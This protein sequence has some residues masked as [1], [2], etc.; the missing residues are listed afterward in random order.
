MPTIIPSTERFALRRVPSAMIDGII[1]TVP[2]ALILTRR[3]PLVDEWPLLAAL[4]AAFTVGRVCMLSLLWPPSEVSWDREGLRIGD[5]SHAAVILWSDFGGY[6]LTWDLPRR[7]KVRRL[8]TADA[9]RIPLA[10]FGDDDQEALMRELS[11]HQV[12]LPNRRLEP[13]RGMIKE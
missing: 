7:V 12:A 3:H 10:A 1:A 5:P 6:S 2:F 11:L 13:T 8:S 4:I 9:V